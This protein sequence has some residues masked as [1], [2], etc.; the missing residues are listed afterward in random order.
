MADFSSEGSISRFKMNRPS[1]GS[2]TCED[3]GAKS[4]AL[5]RRFI[6]KIRRPEINSRRTSIWRG[7]S[8]NSGAATSY[9][10]FFNTETTEKRQR[11]IYPHQSQQLP[12]QSVRFK[13]TFYII[14]IEF[15]ITEI[16]RDYRE[17]TE[18]LWN[19]FISRISYILSP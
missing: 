6:E 13:I 7:F 5:E 2:K 9:S 19:L 16:S 3:W 14:R 11:F 12:I 8:G 18:E 17:R 1:G 10:Y 4:G 15:E